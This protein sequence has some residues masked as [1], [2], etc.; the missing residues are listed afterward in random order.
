MPLFWC[1]DGIVLMCLWHCSD[2]L[3]ALFW[4]AYGIVLMC[5]WHCSDVLMPLFWCAYS[6]V[7][8]C[9]C[10]CSEV[11]MA[12]FWCDYAIVLMCLWHCSD[13]S[14][15]DKVILYFIN[16]FS[17]HTTY[18][19]SHMFPNGST[20]TG[21]SFSFTFITSCKHTIWTILYHTLIYLSARLQ[22][23]VNA[24]TSITIYCDR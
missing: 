17:Y 11:L 1:A 5:L 21:Y 6:I 24:T 15:P 20:S 7:L 12:L 22:S 18:I 14:Y 8:M 9:L 16:L 19:I 23:G 13:A 4:C 2:V 3:M 10:H